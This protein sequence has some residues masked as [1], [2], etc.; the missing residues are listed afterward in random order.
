MH[1]KAL[2]GLRSRSRKRRVFHQ[3]I[4]LGNKD[5]AIK[6]Y[7]NDRFIIKGFGEA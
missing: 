6:A 3:D 1:E 7:N 4:D 2:S 5:F